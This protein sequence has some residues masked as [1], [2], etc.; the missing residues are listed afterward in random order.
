VARSADP[1]RRVRRSCRCRPVRAELAADTGELIT[2][3]LYYP[4]P[5][6]A[7]ALALQTIMSSPEIGASNVRIMYYLSIICARRTILI[8]NPYFVPD[9]AARD[10]LIEAQRRGVK[11]ASWWRPSTTTT[12]WR[13]HNSVRVYRRLLEAGIE[14]L[15]YNRTMLHLKTMAVDGKWFTIGTTNFDKPVVRPQRGEQHLRLRRGAGDAAPDMF[16]RDAES[17]DRVDL[18]T[19]KRRGLWRRV[20]EV[21]AAFGEEQI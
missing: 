3:P 21:F 13:N 9:A 14:I 6:T 1:R 2:G 12:G 19:W 7:G 15:E 17:C 5:E 18:E 16:E 4:L 8:A 20:Q 11:V 10:A